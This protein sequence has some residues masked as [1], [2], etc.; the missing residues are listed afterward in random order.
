[1]STIVHARVVRIHPFADGN[2]RVARLATLL[3]M[4]Q[5]GC[6]FLKQAALE[7]F[8]NAD[9]KRYFRA[10][11]T[12]D[13]GRR[14]P[15]TRWLDY[16]AEGVVQTLGRHRAALPARAVQGAL[17]MQA[18]H[19]LRLRAPQLELYARLT[20]GQPVTAAEYAERYGVSLRTAQYHLQALV[21]GGLLRPRGARKGRRVISP[22]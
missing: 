11:R 5:Q 7:P 21:A 9:R 15:M 17:P 20:P 13:A 2:G 1:M 6:R 16:F 12:L 8:Y 3:V 19:P 10:L 4:R 18:G 22:H 14:D